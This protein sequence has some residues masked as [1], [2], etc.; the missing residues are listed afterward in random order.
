[1]KITVTQQNIDAGLRGSC[2]KD[3]IALSLIEA[4]GNKEVWASP[5][6][7]VWWENGKRKWAHTPPEVCAFMEAF[8]NHG[9]VLPAK[10][11]I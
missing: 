1:M 5:S 2:T 4:S 8:D 10:F 9:G 7:L 11:E 3:P 6:F